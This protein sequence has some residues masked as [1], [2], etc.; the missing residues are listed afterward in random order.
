[1]QYH[2]LDLVLTLYGVAVAG[3]AP[4]KQVGT[5]H[6]LTG[7]FTTVLL[8]PARIWSSDISGNTWICDW[9]LSILCSP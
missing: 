4:H 3:S 7:N 9:I 2:L 5:M 1:M 8:G 6:H